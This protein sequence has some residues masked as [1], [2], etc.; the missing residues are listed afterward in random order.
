MNTYTPV[1]RLLPQMSFRQVF[2]TTQ[3]LTT[4]PTVTL[5]AVLRA[6]P[7]LIINMAVTTTKILFIR[8]RNKEQI[9][10]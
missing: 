2:L 1:L 4:T 8:T 10:R 7:R 9:Q 5:I 6:S 3:S